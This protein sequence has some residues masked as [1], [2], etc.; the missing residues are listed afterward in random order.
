MRAVRAAE[1]AVLFLLAPATLALAMRPWMVFP[2]I[3]LLG[4]TC[5]VLLLRD[6]SFDRQRLWNSRGLLHAGRASMF[7]FGVAAPALALIL[8]A[9]QPDRLFALPRER[10]GL[11]AV[12]MVGY[13]VLSVYAQ[14]LAFRAFFFHRYAVLFASPRAMIAAS[15][16]AFAYAHVI[17]H[18]W[19]AVAF[20]LIGGVL[21]GATYHRTRSLLATSLEHAIYGCFLFTVGWGWY[22]YAGTSVR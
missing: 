16:V 1:C 11:W 10:P 5:L 22:F 19:I 14:E 13:P 7:A 9:L 12:I 2:A 6:P 20:S 18:N 15:A 4:A 3:W 8:L 17:M 21:F